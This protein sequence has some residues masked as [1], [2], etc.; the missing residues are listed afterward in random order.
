[1]ALETISR[2]HVIRGVEPK[3]LYDI[4]TDYG[5][6]P[7]IFPEFTG[8]KVVKDE[9]DVK[10][11]EFRAKLVVEV[12]YVLEIRHDPEKLTTKWTFVEGEVV[13]D[14]AGGWAFSKAG[15]DAKIQYHA[16]MS[17]KAP[18]PKFVLNKVSNLLM[19]S[20]IPNMF[21]ALEREATARR[22][23]AR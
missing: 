20:S 13:S 1:M 11:V 9:G 21:K 2:E 3:L 10:R 22:Q 15:D 18:L 14:S 6:Y 4:V 23:Y 8:C 16:G 19:G 7:R 12:R 17:V 5:C